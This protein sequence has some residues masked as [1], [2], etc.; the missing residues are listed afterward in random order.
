M[1]FRYSTYKRRAK[2]D[3]SGETL[4]SNTSEAVPRNE[5]SS[6]IYFAT[7]QSTFIKIS[8]QKASKARDQNPEGFS[9]QLLLFFFLLIKNKPDH[10]AEQIRSAGDEILYFD[11]GDFAD[12]SWFARD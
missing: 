5:S 4:A 8:K 2:K 6:Y 7:Y 1:K 10:A 12:A 11:A 3:C 9:L